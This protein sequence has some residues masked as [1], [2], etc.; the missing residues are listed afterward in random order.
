MFLFFWCG[1]LS[2]RLPSSSFL[3]SV[4]SSLLLLFFAIWGY[5][6][7]A[8]SRIRERLEYLIIPVQSL[9]AFFYFLGGG[10]ISGV[11]KR[12]RVWRPFFS[13]LIFFQYN[14]FFLLEY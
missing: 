10:F 4:Q 2:L 1:V 3:L 7:P 13:S 14:F 5:Y 8:F 6:P 11:S 9:G 12:F